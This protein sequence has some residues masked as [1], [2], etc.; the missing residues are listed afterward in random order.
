MMSE[1][2]LQKMVN[3]NIVKERIKKLHKATLS[4]LMTEL[5]WTA[6]KLSNILRSLVS[7]EEIIETLYPDY[8]KRLFKVFYSIKPL[9]LPLSV[10]SAS[11]Q[12][13]SVEIPRYYKFLNELFNLILN[14]E[15]NEILIEYIENMNVSI[16]Q[17][18][19]M[20]KEAE[21]ADL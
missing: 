17:I 13:V 16:E 3:E 20:Q 11:Q 2:S 4:D 14:S 19:G 8:E 9:D 5:D 21:E 7:K 15:N 6:G 1:R 10:V 18:I 12:Q